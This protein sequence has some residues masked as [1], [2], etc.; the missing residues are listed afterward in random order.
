MR[1]KNLV[2]LLG[3][4]PKRLTGAVVR[5]CVRVCVHAHNVT[6]PLLFRD[7]GT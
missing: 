3:A 4:T 2:S 7:P 5:A 6:I 1:D